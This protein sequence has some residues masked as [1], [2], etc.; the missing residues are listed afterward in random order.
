MALGSCC[1]NLTVPNDSLAA[2]FASY[3]WQER[4]RSNALIGQVKY[5]LKCP[6]GTGLSHYPSR[7]GMSTELATLYTGLFDAAT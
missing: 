2:C 6:V 1:N 4:L 3:R 7:T 5:Y